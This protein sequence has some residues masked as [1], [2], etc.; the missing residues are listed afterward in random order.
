MEAK[1]RHIFDET[2]KKTIELA[3]DIYKHPE[4]GYKEI[5]TAGK[6][7]EILEAEGIPYTDQVAY[8]GILS[9]LDSGRPGPHIGLICEL[10]AVPTLNHPYANKEDYA[11]HTCGHYAQIGA[12]MG[13][14]LSLHKAN[15]IGELCGKV[16][17]V[18]TPA[19][20]FCDLEYR[21]GLI[22][23]GKIKHVSGKQEMIELGVFD[24]MALILSCHTMGLDMNVYDAEIGAGLN[25]F[26]CKKAIFHGRGAHAGSNP[27]GGINALNAANL[28]MSGINFLRETFREEDAIRVHFV[29]TEGGQTVNTVPERVTMEMYV[30][31][32]TVD[33]ILETDKKVTRALRAGALAIGCDLEIVDTPG[34]LPLH[35]DKNL[36][37]LVKT[38]ILNYIAPE[39]IAQGTHG[40]ASGDMGDLSSLYPIVEIG[41]GGFTGTMHGSDFRTTDYEQAYH[42]PAAYF[43][44]TIVDL[45]SD[46]GKKAYEIQE[47]FNPIMSKESYLAMLDRFNKTTIY[48][49]G[50]QEDEKEMG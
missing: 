36:T 17:L 27:A 3:E 30:R 24:D 1:V 19:E 8:T 21:R 11:A 16:T 29:I 2:I 44:D 12:M 34:Y 18:V 26:L 31:A 9:T 35:Q 39:R 4:L 14:F 47:K 38:H 32:K 41:V 5:R 10:D 45:L 46:G 42:V 23:E 37:E 40:F 49:K 13:V 50:E 20:E 43:I 25:G 6:V 15:I 22:A 33:A 28:A 48:K 7:K